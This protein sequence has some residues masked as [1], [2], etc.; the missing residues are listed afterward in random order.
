MPSRNYWMRI[1]LCRA[2]Q[3]FAV[4]SQIHPTTHMGVVVV[5]VGCGCICVSVCM[6]LLGIYSGPIVSFGI[7]LMHQTER[8]RRGDGGASSVIAENGARSGTGRCKRSALKQRNVGTPFASGVVRIV[9]QMEMLYI[10][11]Y[12]FVIDCITCSYSR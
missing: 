11:P 1:I 8:K 10:E 12:R 6:L 2:N 7:C 5:I 3:N 4:C 9:P